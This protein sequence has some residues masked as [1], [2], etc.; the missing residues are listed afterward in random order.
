LSKYSTILCDL[1]FL[2]FFR[3][4]KL[5]DHLFTTFSTQQSRSAV[6]ET[7]KCPL[8]PGGIGQLVCQ[9]LGLSATQPYLLLWATLCQRGGAS[10][11]ATLALLKALGFCPSFRWIKPGRGCVVTSP[12]SG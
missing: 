2:S 7:G 12:V 3:P 6:W 5:S 8:L 4:R 11:V 10:N 9:A 1:L